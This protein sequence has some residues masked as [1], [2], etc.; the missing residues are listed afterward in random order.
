MLRY[1]IGPQSRIAADAAEEQLLKLSLD[2]LSHYDSSCR[3]SH[4]GTSEGRGDVTIKPLSATVTGGTRVHLTSESTL[5]CFYVR[6]RDFGGMQS[7]S[8]CCCTTNGS[9][10]PLRSNHGAC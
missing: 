8:Q 10:V 3:A 4:T 2:L 9:F 5:N 6:Q 7:P 1:G